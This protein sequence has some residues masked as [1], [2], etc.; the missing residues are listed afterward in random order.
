MRKL[1]PFKH[2]LPAAVI[3]GAVGISFTMVLAKPGGDGL[4]AGT[5]IVS[6]AGY[7]GPMDLRTDSVGVPRQA[8]SE[9]LVQFYTKYGLLGTVVGDG[10]LSFAIIE[11]RELKRQRIYRIGHLIHGGVVTAILKDEVLVRFGGKDAILKMGGGSGSMP[12]IA[13]AQTGQGERQVVTVSLKG[14]RN[15]LEDFSGSG[16][17]ARM[18]PQ[19]SGSGKGGFQ[20]SNVDAE[21]A[22]G[23]LGLKSG[24][25][26]EEI[27][28]KRI[29]DPYNAVAMFNLMKSVL[30]E[31][32]FNEIGLDLPGFLDGINNHRLST[33]QKI[34]SL[35]K[36][37]GNTQLTLTVKRRV[38]KP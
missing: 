23:A 13:A 9:Q 31:D 16:S 28:G 24:D 33:Y 14:L 12:V 4:R 10:N 21:S 29:Q 32:A 25:V 19:P 15:V 36:K 27:N 1:I 35:L 6:T 37:K 18:V 17:G 34:S 3:L 2:F 20:L 11:D 5:A 26:I 30:P 22:L 8:T 38:V 7:G